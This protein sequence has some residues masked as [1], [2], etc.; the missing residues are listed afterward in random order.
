LAGVVNA[1]MQICFAKLGEI[2]DY[3]NQYQI[4]KQEISVELIGKGF[5]FVANA[6][7]KLS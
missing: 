6:P 2:F 3:L 5:D 7:I 1:E 4:L